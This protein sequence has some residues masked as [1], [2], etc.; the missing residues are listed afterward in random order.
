MR[1]RGKARL[2][3]GVALLV[4]LLSACA[5]NLSQST[6][7]PAG[8]VAE[9]QKS[10][11]ELV[12]WIAVVVFVLVE[13]ILVFAIVRYRHR[14]GNAIPEQT[15]GNLKLEIGWTIVPTLLLAGLAVPAVTTVY[16]LAREPTGDDVINVRVVGHQWWWEFDYPDLGI[17]TANQMHIPEDTPVFI[18]LN[19]VGATKGGTPVGIPGS[20]EPPPAVGFAVIHS[21]WPA[22]LAGKTDVVPGRTNTMTIEGSEPGVYPDQCAEFCGL[23]HTLMR[24]EVIVDTQEGFESWVRTNQA[25]AADPTDPLALKGMQIFSEQCIACHTVD[26]AELNQRQFAGIGGPNMTHFA[27]R[28]CFAGCFLQNNPDTVRRWVRDPPAMKPGSFMPDYALTEDQ[29]DAVVAYLETLE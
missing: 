26:G 24:F 23:S 20:K 8:P 16:D 1:V 11:F 6:L 27:S 28:T 15:H 3:G 4:L 5:D 18:E 29:I 10:L 14:K 17:T 12:F 13:G 9:K 22:R 21:F 2:V 25:D 7:N 19:A